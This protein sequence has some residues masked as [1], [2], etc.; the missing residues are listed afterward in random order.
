MY[1]RMSNGNCY[2]KKK[3]RGVVYGD[4][5]PG[6]KY[7][8]YQGDNYVEKN[9]A[10]DKPI[11]R[12]TYY[13][14]NQSIRIEVVKVRPMGVENRLLFLISIYDNNWK[15]FRD[16]DPSN[17][18]YKGQLYSF[19]LTEDEENKKFDEFKEL[20]NG[21]MMLA[22]NV[23][24]V[25]VFPRR[26]NRT[27]YEA[28]FLSLNTINLTNE[29]L[30]ELMK[31]YPIYFNT[32]YSLELSYFDSTYPIKGVAEKYINKQKRN[33]YQLV[34]NYYEL[35]RLIEIL[36]YVDSVVSNVNS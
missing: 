25:H 2:R 16:W 28:T 26:K 30:A 11:I 8:K 23:N 13:N 21:L 14:D 33:N 20:I 24:T 19:S 1:Y 34:L 12:Q 3:K 10:L 6:Y 32:Y 36:S 22:N 18:T 4:F 17:P 27:M 15:E 7:E 29:Q 5:D 9:C 35:I 31:S